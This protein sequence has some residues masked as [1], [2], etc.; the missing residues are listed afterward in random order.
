MSYSES[1]VE[2]LIPGAAAGFLATLPMT[3]TMAIARSVLPEDQQHPLPPRRVVG[4]VSEK[5][6]LD[7]HLDEEGQEAVTAVVHFAFGAAAGTLY[8]LLFGNH[9]NR[10]L[11]GTG[12]GLAVWAGSYMGWLPALDIL[13][14][15]HRESKGWI[16]MNVLAHVVW[17]LSTAAM[18]N[19]L[20][21]PMEEVPE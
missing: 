18:V 5:T 4:S 20:S 1:T 21:T 12:F 3:A 14:P 7:E 19:Q 6:G 9:E 8:S 15:A 10:V 11:A 17:G 2:R 16:G 13:P